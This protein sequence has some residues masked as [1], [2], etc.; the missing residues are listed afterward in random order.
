MTSNTGKNWAEHFSENP[1][2]L[3]I[4]CSI[5]VIQF[6]SANRFE[7]ICSALKFTNALPLTIDINFMKSK[8]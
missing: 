2:D 1:M 5:R 7:S 3:F 8:I 6:M 4:G